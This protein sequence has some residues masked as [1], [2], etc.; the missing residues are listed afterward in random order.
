MGGMFGLDEAFVGAADGLEVVVLEDT[1]FI[2][3]ETR[4]IVF[5]NLFFLFEGRH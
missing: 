4:V 1:V 2:F 3:V 5:T